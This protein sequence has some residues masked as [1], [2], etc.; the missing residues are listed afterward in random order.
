LSAEDEEEEATR[1]IEEEEV[2]VR[3]TSF[4]TSLR[5]VSIE[6]RDSWFETASVVWSEFNDEGSA[7]RR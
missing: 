5:M 2:E 4:R 7:L 3:R 6:G 1:A